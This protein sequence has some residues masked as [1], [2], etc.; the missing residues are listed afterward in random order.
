MYCPKCRCEFIEGIE[1]CPDCNVKLVEKLPEK[2]KPQGDPNIKMAA[3]F[4]SADRGLIAI[5]K[6]LLEE[7]NI[8]YFTSG[9]DFKNFFGAVTG[10]VEIIVREDDKENALAILSDL[11]GE[12]TKE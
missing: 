2:E 5:A 11:S 9:E 6:S 7:E 8:D 1:I 3:V 10:E 12:T 4:I